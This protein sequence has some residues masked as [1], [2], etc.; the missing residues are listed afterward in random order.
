MTLKRL[1]IYSWNLNGIRAAVRNGFLDWLQKEQPDI[2]LMQEV[3][4]A[5]ADL[6]PEWLEP[7]GY[8]S[9][10]HSAAKKGYSGVGIYSKVAVAAENVIVGLGDPQFDSEGR[11]LGIVHE[12]I[13]IASA[14]FPNSQRDTLR[15]PYK[16]DYCNLV[17]EF[18]N[19]QRSLGREVVLGGDFNIAHTPLDLA[20]PKQNEKNA[21]YLPEERDWMTRFIEAGY[22]DTFR[23][24]EKGGG[25]YTWWSQR[26]GIRERNIGWRLDYHF[27]T[28]GLVDRVVTARIFPSVLGSDHCPV[29]LEL[30]LK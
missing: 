13:L 10:W 11:F 15:L 17:L 25:H 6:N 21:G 20:N 5:D 1:K 8:K 3:R 28:P 16:L 18:L 19:R 14:Y 30:N 27:I 12:N 26:P 7:F 4:C 24:F 9:Y 22:V 23:L 2:L 29:S